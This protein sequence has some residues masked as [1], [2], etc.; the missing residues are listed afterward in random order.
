MP[1]DAAVRVRALT[2]S[3]RGA[4]G[5]GAVF[6]YILA[7]AMNC[8]S[9]LDS[10]SLASVPMPLSVHSAGKKYSMIDSGSKS[11]PLTWSAV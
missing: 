1:I 3:A 11:V 2:L 6:G 8:L 9:I 10:T 7:P 4:I 5:V